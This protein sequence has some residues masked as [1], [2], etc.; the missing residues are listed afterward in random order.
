MCVYTYTSCHVFLYVHTH[1][2]G[3]G[4]T[5]AVSTYIVDKHTHVYTCL[6]IELVLYIDLHK[7][8]T[9]IFMCVHI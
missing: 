8:I 5:V 6:C 2:D 4:I 1:I 9:F 7:F 3:R